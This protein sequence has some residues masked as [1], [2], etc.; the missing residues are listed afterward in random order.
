MRHNL[1]RLLEEAR[2][3]TT[4]SGR[5]GE[6][7]KGWMRLE[8]SFSQCGRKTYIGLQKKKYFKYGPETVLCVRK[9]GAAGRRLCEEKTGDTQ[10][11]GS[12]ACEPPGGEKQEPG[13]EYQSGVCGI[14]CCR[15]VL[16]SFLCVMYLRLQ[17]EV[18]NHSETS[19][20]CRRISRILQRQTIQR[21]TA[22]E[23]LSIWKRSATR[24]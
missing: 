11:K 4:A 22:A 13:D 19:P 9:C 14:S 15:S 21:T 12:A 18:V 23:I 20:L 3:G 2:A 24:P 17:S 16:R 8:R 10:E 6:S 1:H 7:P 5:E